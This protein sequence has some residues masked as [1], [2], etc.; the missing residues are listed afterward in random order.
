MKNFNKSIVTWWL[1]KSKHVRYMQWTYYL[2]YLINVGKKGFL[3][4]NNDIYAIIVYV[5]FLNTHVL[6][7]ILT[8]E[9]NS[10]ID[11]IFSK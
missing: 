4:T 2:W 5:I 7:N 8:L 3:N 9:H 6:L 11:Q 1:I 10:F